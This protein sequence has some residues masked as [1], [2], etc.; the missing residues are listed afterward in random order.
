MATIKK[1]RKYEDGGKKKKPTPT[2][3]NL[4][5]GVKAQYETLTGETRSNI[6][7]TGKDSA[8]YRGGF[9][10]GLKN[11]GKKNIKPVPGESPVQR[12]GRWEGQNTPQKKKGGAVKKYQDGGMTGFEK[13]QAKKVGRAQTRAADPPKACKNL[14]PMSAGKVVAVVQSNDAIK[15]M[16]IPK[17]DGFLR[18]NRSEIGP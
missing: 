2:Y 10:I 3:K 11:R 15:K 7:P 12:S 13:R 4:P 16:R 1:V 6:K 9:E 18:P 8:D 14:K 17:Y 5:M